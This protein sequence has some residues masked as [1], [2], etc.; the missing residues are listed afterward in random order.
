MH[1][2]NSF[3]IIAIF[4]FNMNISEFFELKKK[5]DFYLDSEIFLGKCSFDFDKIDV[6][7]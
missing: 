6:A 3:T 2:I 4:M 1:L 5:P 7:C